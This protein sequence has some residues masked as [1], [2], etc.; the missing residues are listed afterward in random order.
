MQEATKHV[1]S[2]L[3]ELGGD[4]N[5]QVTELKNQTAALKKWERENA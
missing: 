5:V 3:A 4:W 1:T 2:E